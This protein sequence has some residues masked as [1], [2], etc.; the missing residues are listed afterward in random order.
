[1][2]SVAYFVVAVLALAGFAAAGKKSFVPGGTIL[3]IQSTAGTFPEKSVVG[4]RGVRDLFNRRRAAVVE[5]SAEDSR[6]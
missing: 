6:D 4:P 5:E 1:M 2:K 3:D